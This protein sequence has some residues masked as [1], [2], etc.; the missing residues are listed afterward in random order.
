[1]K[2]T[3][4]AESHISDTLQESCSTLIDVNTNC[5]SVVVNAPASEVYR[6]CLRFEDLPR[7]ITSI[8]SIDRINDTRF[9]CSVMANGQET[10]SVVQ[11][12][13]RVSDR[14]IAW[15]AVS[16]NFRVGVVTFDPV[17][18][19]RTKVSVKLRSIVDPVLLSGTL[20]RYLDN[21]KIEI[22]QAEARA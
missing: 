19:G 7:F 12:M 1:M 17:S 8:V 11:I 3:Q 5:Q 21:F 20:R 4:N 15:Q 10:Q 6:R 13:M 18:A 16:E 9:T 14:R 22:E 2:A